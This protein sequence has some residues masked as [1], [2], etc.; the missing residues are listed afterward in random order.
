MTCRSLDWCMTASSINHNVFPHWSAALK[1]DFLMWQ[2]VSS[3]QPSNQRQWS[4]AAVLHKRG[5]DKQWQPEINP[6]HGRTRFDWPLPNKHTNIACE[7]GNNTRQTS[8]GDMWVDRR[9]SKRKF[10]VLTPLN[11]PISRELVPLNGEI[12]REAA[13]SAKRSRCNLYSSLHRGWFLSFDKS[14]RH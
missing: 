2:S 4:A 8:T 7:T 1:I 13:A 3:A 12:H 11:D 5:R 9:V 10:L 6:G 14:T